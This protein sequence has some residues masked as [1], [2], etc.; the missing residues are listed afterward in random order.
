MRIP[1]AVNPA[2]TAYSADVKRPSP[3]VGT[4]TLARAPPH[5]VLP[6]S[7]SALSVSYDVVYA[8]H[9]FSISR[10]RRTCEMRSVEKVGRPP[11][12]MAAA[13]LVIALSLA[14]CNDESR[15][16]MPSAPDITKDV[17]VSQINLD[18]TFNFFSVDVSI[19]SSC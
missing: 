5:K 2:C 18:S 3:E 13:I 12:R 16:V 7:Y 6:P 4:A 9:V 14:G 1:L 19:P 15:S 17:V 11:Y 8:A 10:N